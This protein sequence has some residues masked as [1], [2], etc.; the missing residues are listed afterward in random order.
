MRVR[1][2]LLS[3]LL[4]DKISFNITFKLYEYLFV[5]YIFIHIYLSGSFYIFAPDFFCITFCIF[6]LEPYVAL[7]QKVE[8]IERTE[9]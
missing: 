2:T 6:I 5:L 9:I 8:K 4:P 3:T 1:F 7:V